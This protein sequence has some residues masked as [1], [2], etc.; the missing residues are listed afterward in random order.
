AEIR[1]FAEIERLDSTGLHAMCPLLNDE[2]VLGIADLRGTRLDTH[3]LLQGNLRALRAARGALH[4]G[5]RAARIERENDLWTVTSEKGERF[6]A[7]ILINAAGSWADTIADLAGVQPLG[8][9]PKRR[10]IITFDAPDGVELDGLPFAK[11]V[12]DD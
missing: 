3:A 4:A 2:A 6:A 11:T 5:H 7:P 9:E 12:G 10:T 8:L 1:Q